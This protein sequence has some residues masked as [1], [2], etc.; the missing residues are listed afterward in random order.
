MK[1]AVRDISEESP[2]FLKFSDQDQPWFGDLMKDVL[3]DRDLRQ[4]S[5]QLELTLSRIDDTVSLRGF[6][7]GTLQL[8]CDRCLE[9]FDDEMYSELRQDLIPEPDRRHLSKEERTAFQKHREDQ[10]LTY[11]E[12]DSVDLD[13]LLQDQLFVERPIQFLCGEECRGLC[14]ACGCN[15]N[16]LVCTCSQGSSHQP[17]AALSTLRFS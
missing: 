5:V 17:F 12:H 11:Y 7:A 16:R 10:P 13:L 2:L 3:G 9:T 15:L 4:G 6:V 1:I 8:D 14:V